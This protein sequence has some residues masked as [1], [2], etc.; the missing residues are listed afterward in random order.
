MASGGGNPGGG[1]LPGPG[2]SHAQV[3]VQR[4][5]V[6]SQI[7]RQP[8]WPL[9]GSFTQNQLFSRPSGPPKRQAT[10]DLRPLLSAPN[11]GALNVNLLSANE[12]QLY[13]QRRLASIAG[14]TSITYNDD[15][16]GTR[17]IRLYF[18]GQNHQLIGIEWFEA[19]PQKIGPPKAGANSRPGGGST[20]P[21]GGVQPRPGGG[22]AIGPGG[23]P[24]PGGGAAID[25]GGL[26]VPAIGIPSPAIE[27]RP[28]GRPRL[29]GQPK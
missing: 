26:P 14:C 22:P 19:G 5:M 28:Q 1:I 8:Q 4:W 29:K 9:V 17:G 7:A 24:R 12:R 18:R 16:Q 11:T 13:S 25:P 15:L 10:F 27:G 21:G 3:T 6:L 23:L 2:G 20:R